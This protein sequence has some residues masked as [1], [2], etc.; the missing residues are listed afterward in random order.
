MATGDS[1]AD[2]IRLSLWFAYLT[3]LNE[4]AM[5]PIA[6]LLDSTRECEALDLDVGM[7]RQQATKTILGLGQHSFYYFDTL[8]VCH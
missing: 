5:R 8:E 7:P 4:I 3:V 2:A 6:Q 1:G